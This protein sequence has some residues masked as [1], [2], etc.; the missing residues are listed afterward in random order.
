MLKNALKLSFLGFLAGIVVCNIITALCSYA[1]TGV[2]LSFAPELA[3]KAGSELNAFLIQLLLAGLDG[4][5][6]MGTTVIYDIEKFPL[7]LS[8]AIHF[9]ITMLVYIPI[10]FYLCWVTT[11]SEILIIMAI[12]AAAYLCIWLIMNLIYRKEVKKL[13]QLQEEHLRHQNI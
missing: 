5:V 13:N 11:I 3:E 4:A 8:T 7:V 12:M 6:C 1:Q 9:L 2:I 10:A